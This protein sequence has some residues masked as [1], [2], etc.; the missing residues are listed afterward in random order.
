MITNTVPH[1]ISGGGSGSGF[2][3]ATISVNLD[4]MPTIATGLENASRHCA[5][6]ALPLSAIA[7]E[8][9]LFLGVNSR[10]QRVSSQCTTL[11]VGMGESSLELEATALAVRVAHGAYLQTENLVAGWFDSLGMTADGKL[12]DG[13]TPRDAIRGFI[14]GDPGE[15]E[16]LLMLAVPGLGYFGARV[17]LPYSPAVAAALFGASAYLD[18]QWN[19]SIARR[20]AAENL[21]R[22]TGIPADFIE[23]ALAL[24]GIGIVGSLRSPGSGR[25]AYNVRTASA[26]KYSIGS[27][28]G[29]KDRLTV[30]ASAERLQAVSAAQD[31]EF[32]ESQKDLS[33]GERGAVLVTV[34]YDEGYYGDPAHALYVVSIP[35]TNF[36]SLGGAPID[37]SG[38]L[39]ESIG[40]DTVNN[41][42]YA[43]VLQALVDAGAPQGARVYLEGFSQGGMIAYNMANS[44]E[45]AKEINIVGVY[46][47]ASPLRGLPAKRRDFTVDYVEGEG[48]WVP[49][50]ALRTEGGWRPDEQDTEITIHNSEHDGGKYRET[51]QREGYGHRSLSALHTA[52]NIRDYVQGEQTVTS[53]SAMPDG[54]TAEERT[55]EFLR[56]TGEYG[57]RAAEAGVTVDSLGIYEAINQATGGR[58]GQIVAGAK[59]TSQVVTAETK[60]GVSTLGRDFEVVRIAVDAV[61]RKTEEIVGETVEASRDIVER[62]EES[63]PHPEPRLEEKLEEL[64]RPFH[65]DSQNISAAITIPDLSDSNRGPLQ[66]PFPT[67]PNLSLAPNLIPSD[68]LPEP[69][70]RAEFGGKVKVPTPE[71]LGLPILGGALFEPRQGWEIEGRGDLPITTEPLPAPVFPAEEIDP[72]L[73]SPHAP[74]EDIERLNEAELAIT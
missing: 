13:R 7:T 36:A 19:P 38:T 58:L 8:T 71:E 61:S 72:R 44:T 24:G 18:M 63:I 69:A 28:R 20:R 10:A 14:A 47:Q 73:L 54:Y 67:E 1:L 35:G 37:A 70:A 56:R 48:D 6:R 9:M 4:E 53:A 30:D 32:E 60:R 65:D 33:R 31:R 27:H 23:K 41:P 2:T 74:G 12:P 64:P 16:Y 50:S 55:N 21:S 26:E 42:A 62:I 11:A 22:M 17:A 15:G 5:E 25:K 29:E 39:R 34:M 51:L 57:A 43:M 40:E 45:V 68:L 46:A 3:G 59:V 52:T 66:M 49:D